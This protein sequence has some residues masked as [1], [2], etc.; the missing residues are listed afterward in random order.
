MTSFEKWMEN[1]PNHKYT[2]VTIKRYTR[3]LDKVGEWLNITLSKSIR[4]YRLPKKYIM[5]I[6]SY[7]ASDDNI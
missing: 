7:T 6:I 2:D 4:H 5:A 1:N 3:A